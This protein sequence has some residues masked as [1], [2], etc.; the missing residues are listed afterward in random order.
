MLLLVDSRA[1]AQ[2]MPGYTAPQLAC[3]RFHESVRSDL[4]LQT[5][6]RT[7]TANTGRDSYLIVAAREA[8]TPPAV[9]VVAW[10]DS[11]RVWRSAGGNRQ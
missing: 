7:A 8:S 4:T 10:F 2:S 1:E 5:A 9:L 3:A 6:G 11:L